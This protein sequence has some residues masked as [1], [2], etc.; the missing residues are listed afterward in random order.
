M[1]LD[2]TI[3]LWRTSDL[4]LHGTLKGHK[5]GVWDCQFSQ[6]DRVLATGSGDRTV[7]LWSIADCSCVRTFQGHMASVLRVR[8]IGTG[9]QL[10]SSGSD[11][12]IKLWTIRTNECESTIDGHDDKIWALDLS[13]T[14]G[15]LF[16]GGADS[17]IAVWRDTTKEKDD[18]KR[19]AEEKNIL[20]EQTLSNHLRHKRYEQALELALELDKPQQVLKVLTDILEKDAAS[21]RGIETLQK[22]AANW[23]LDKLVQI[24]RYCREWNT[25]ARN[26]HIAMLV[27][28]AIVTTIPAAKLATYQGVP[29]IL[30]GIA[31]YAERHFE[32]LDG[33]V[34]NSYLLDYTLFS[35]GSIHG[36]SKVEGY[37]EWLANRKYLPPKVQ[38][39]RI[40]IGGSL[41]VE[42]KKGHN[43]EKDG[44]SD[45]DVMTIGD[46]DTEDED[47]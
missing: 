6:H 15:T 25:R 32:R 24:L 10:L 34:G 37:D 23:Q 7:K 18:E 47:E 12:L 3:K 2:K 39:G 40:Q 16:S 36:E 28:K 22:H 8:F 14:T 1:Y 41:I 4:A 5:R 38:E 46:S 31:P 11:G 26:S 45:E 43:D 20:M 42:G 9:L 27:V 29:E 35:M 17:K 33:M 13:Q 44:S 30:A 21:S 19:E